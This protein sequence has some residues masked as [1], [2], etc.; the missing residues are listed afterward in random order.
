VAG[1]YKWLLCP[2]GLA[3]F[4]VSPDRLLEIEPWFAGWKSIDDV[5]ERYYGMPKN[6][7]AGARRLDASL[8]WLLAEGSRASLSL[9]ETLGVDAIAAHDRSLAARFSAELGLEDSGSAIVQVERPDA[10]EAAERL[11]TAGIKCSVRAGALRFAFH[12]YNDEGDVGRAL[13]VL[14]RP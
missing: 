3:F 7:T 8:P 4:Y 9:I 14:G 12:L 2:R 1:G 11:R 6:L 5:Y 13:D 10:E